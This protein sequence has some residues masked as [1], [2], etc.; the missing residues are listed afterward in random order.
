V[1]EMSGKMHLNGRIWNQ[2]Y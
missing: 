2:T 1:A